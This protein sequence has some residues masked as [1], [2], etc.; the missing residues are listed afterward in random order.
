MNAFAILIALFL[1]H[2]S[3]KCMPTSALHNVSHQAREAE[4]CADPSLATVYVSFFSIS[5]TAHILRS[6][7]A[8]VSYD[9]TV[10]NQDNWQFQNPAFLAWSSLQEF[11]TPFYQLISANGDSLDVLPAV[12]GSPPSV[13][14]FTVQAAVG[15]AYTTQICGSVPLLSA[16]NAATTDRWWTTNEV[17][18]AELL[19]SETG[20][21][22]GGVS[23][24]V[25]PLA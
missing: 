6:R 2:I 16:V 21:V 24:Y 18:H 23:F 14:G 12:N 5:R 8:L 19:G 17:E 9:S 3:A 10:A 15:Y 11:T 20:W 7:P 13:A 4:T 25:L 22:D 1:S